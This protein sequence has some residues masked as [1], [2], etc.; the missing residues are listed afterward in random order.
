MRRPHV[1]I[2]RSRVLAIPIRA[3]PTRVIPWPGDTKI[4]MINILSWQPV[5]G[6]WTMQ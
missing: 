4:K 2:D 3:A 5:H 6:G 1:L